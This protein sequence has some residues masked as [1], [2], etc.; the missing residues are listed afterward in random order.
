MAYD[1]ATTPLAAT[2]AIASVPTEDGMARPLLYDGQLIDDAKLG[3]REQRRREITCRIT[4]VVV[5][6][7][8]GLGA[9]TASRI[10]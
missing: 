6:R 3:I 7:T 5:R 2:P 1:A 4:D 10:R 8:D 9:S